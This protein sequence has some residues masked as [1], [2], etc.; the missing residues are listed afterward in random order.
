VAELDP[1]VYGKMKGDMMFFDSIDKL[2]PPILGWATGGE[3]SEG[4]DNEE[5]K[6]E[7]E[8]EEEGDPEPEPQ[9]EEPELEAQEED[10][11]SRPTQC[12]RK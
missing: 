1:H 11:Q 6:P 3:N 10:T 12:K 7:P 2:F 5:S 8:E 4:D 9:E